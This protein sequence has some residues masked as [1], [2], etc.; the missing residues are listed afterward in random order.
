MVGGAKC[1]SFNFFFVFFFFFFFGG[2]GGGRE[3]VGGQFCFGGNVLGSMFFVCVCV[4]R[5]G[6][7]ANVLGD[8]LSGA[9]IRPCHFQNWDGE[10]GGEGGKQMSG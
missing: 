4:W 3:W 7:G 1:S 10:W 8:I 5:E 2:G 6:G 9:N